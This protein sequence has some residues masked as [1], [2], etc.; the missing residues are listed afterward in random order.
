MIPGYGGG[1]SSAKAALESDTRVLAF[2][3]GREYGVRV[4]CISAGPL[5]SRAASA[6]GIIEKMVDYVRANS[7]LTE[8]LTAAEVGTAAAF[9][10]SPLARGIT[11]HRAVRGQGLP[12]DG[13]GGGRPRGLTR[14]P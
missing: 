4:N 13:H 7:P 14:H 12:R 9:L 5:A 3:A 11:G 2:E 8:P 10:S 6:I 1:M